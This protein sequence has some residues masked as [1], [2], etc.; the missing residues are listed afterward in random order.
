[1]HL[2]SQFPRGVIGRSRRYLCGSAC[3]L[4]EALQVGLYHFTLHSGK[5]LR[6]TTAN[7]G[8]EPVKILLRV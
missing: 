4:Q 2:F 6:C 7:E 3:A 1:M 8:V 5:I